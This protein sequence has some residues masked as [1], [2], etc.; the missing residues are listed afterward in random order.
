M[1]GKVIRLNKIEFGYCCNCNNPAPVGVFE[2]KGWFHQF[3]LCSLCLEK[4]AKDIES[5]TAVIQQE[6]INKRNN[7]DE[8]SV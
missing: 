6:L 1:N 3:N 5:Q 7:P 4:F 2:V 8:N